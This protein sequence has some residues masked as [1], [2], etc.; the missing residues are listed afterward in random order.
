MLSQSISD[1]QFGGSR[2]QK[3]NEWLK[4]LQ[5]GNSEQLQQQLDQAQQ[6]MESMLNAE[7]PEERQKLASQLRKQLQDLKKFSSEKASSPELENA[8]NQ[9]LKSLD[10]LARRP[11]SGPLNGTRSET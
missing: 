8:L 5:E 9:A 4:Q 3:M 11:L 10:A 7:T 1:Q 6:T 2:A